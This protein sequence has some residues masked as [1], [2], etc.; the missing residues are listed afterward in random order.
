MT[1]NAGGWFDRLPLTQKTFG[2]QSYEAVNCC[3]CLHSA[4]PIERRALTATGSTISPS[5]AQTQP[6]TSPESK[7]QSLYPLVRQATAREVEEKEEEEEEKQ[8][9]RE[10]CP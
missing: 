5:Q 4:A 9:K 1:V 6:C 10:D 7:Q 2:I 3:V 8:G